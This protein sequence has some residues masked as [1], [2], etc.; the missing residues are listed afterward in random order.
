MSCEIHTY[1]RRHICVDLSSAIRINKFSAELRDN[2]TFQK[3]C[4]YEQ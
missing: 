1:I 4:L 2:V 3:T